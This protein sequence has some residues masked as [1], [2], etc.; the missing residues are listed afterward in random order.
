MQ[1]KKKLNTAKILHE[2]FLSLPKSPKKNEMI[3]FS[4]DVNDHVYSKSKS[5]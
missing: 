3:S 1:K 5:V 2:N 4:C